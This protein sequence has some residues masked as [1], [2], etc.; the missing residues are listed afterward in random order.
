VLYLK[1][2]TD[3]AVATACVKCSHDL[4]GVLVI[5]LD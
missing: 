4:G 3:Q 5:I 1:V 2:P